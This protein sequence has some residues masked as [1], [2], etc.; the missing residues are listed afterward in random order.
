MARAYDEILVDV[1]EDVVGVTLNAPERRN[2]LTATM[3]AEVADALAS[4]VAGG[5]RA[6]VITGAGKGFC[7]GGDIAMMS[8]GLGGTGGRG[9]APASRDGVLAYYRTVMTVAELPVPVVAAVNGAAVGAGLN[10]ALACDVR[11]ASEHAKFYASF[12]RIGLPP[13][14]GASWL[15][16]RAIGAGRAAEMIYSAEPVDA[17]EA[18][19]IGL[20]NRVL[21]AAD[22]VEASWALAAKIAAGPPAAT[23]MTK[24]ALRLASWADHETVL[25]FE[26]MAQASLSG[27]ADLAE[28]LSAFLEKRPPRFEGR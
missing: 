13:G 20:V 28:G 14:M 21:P 8:T 25:Q 5:A 27:T 10:L 15:L 16:Q 24:Q 6:A 18:E 9:G 3:A 2:A 17:T 23:R 22:L 7:S 11:Y 1:R 26:A 4:A 19:R 12:L